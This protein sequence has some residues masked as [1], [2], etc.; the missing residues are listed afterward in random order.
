LIS[1]ARMIAMRN[2]IVDGDS[3]KV[4]LL[5]KAGVPAPGEVDGF[6]FVWLAVSLCKAEIFDLLLGNG[7]LITTPKL[8]E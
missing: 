4:C 2:A 3:A 1:T 6:P 5:L 7:A 8:L